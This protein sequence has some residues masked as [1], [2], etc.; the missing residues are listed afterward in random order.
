MTHNKK[1]GLLVVDDHSLVREGVCAVLDLFAE[2]QVLGEASNGYEALDMV[3]RLRPHV[4]LMDIS[5][6]EMDGF[7]A[8][9]RICKEFPGV[10]VMALTQ[11]ADREHAFQMLEAGAAGFIS[12]SIDSAELLRGIRAVYNGDSFLSPQVAKYLVE[13]FQREELEKKR[14][15]PFQE[16]T[17]RE[18]EILKLFAEGYTTQ[19]IADLLV[20]SYKTVEG[21]KTRLMAKLDLKNRID[22]VKYALRKGIISC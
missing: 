10:K 1:I 3:Q 19:E 17:A 6:P 22:L 9:R 4:V 5:M 20:V 16:L 14:W 8:T 15:D 2:I 13:G 18:R 7:E 11:Y 21:H 12:K